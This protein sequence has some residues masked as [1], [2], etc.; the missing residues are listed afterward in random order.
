MYTS[1]IVTH[2]ASIWQRSIAASRRYTRPRATCGCVPL[3]ALHASATPATASSS[4]LQHSLHQIKCQAKFYRDQSKAPSSVLH[5]LSSLTEQVDDMSP[6][7]WHRIAQVCLQISSMFPADELVQQKVASLAHALARSAMPQLQSW[8]THT[9]PLDIRTVSDFHSW[10]EAIQACGILT[11]LFAQRGVPLAAWHQAV[12]ALARAVP[13]RSWKRV[14]AV[15]SL[16]KAW[17]TEATATAPWPQIVAAVPAWDARSPGAARRAVQM[18]GALA[19]PAADSNTRWPPRTPPPLLAAAVSACLATLATCG[20]GSTSALSTLHACRSASKLI[21]RGAVP[22]QDRSGITRQIEA[23]V[24]A[25]VEPGVAESAGQTRALTVGIAG[26]LLE[27]PGKP[28]AQVAA[29]LVQGSSASL[30]PEA[31]QYG[32]AAWK[33]ALSLV[34]GGPRVLGAQHAQRAT[35]Y[36]DALHA[37]VSA[38]PSVPAAQRVGIACDASAAAARA[39]VLSAQAAQGCLRAI[40]AAPTGWQDVSALRLASWLR[41]VSSLPARRMHELVSSPAWAAQ[42]L[43]LQHAADAMDLTALPAFAVVAVPESYVRLGWPAHAAAVRAAQVLAARFESRAWPTPIAAGIL[44]AAA[45]AGVILRD[46]LAPAQTTA[47]LH[48]LEHRGCTL[49]LLLAASTAWALACAGGAHATAAGVLAASATIASAVHS[50]GAELPRGLGQLVLAHA[51]CEQAGHELPPLPDNIL[52]AGLAHV[53]SARGGA[54]L[55]ST[56]LALPAA[57]ERA[58]PDAA[59]DARTVGCWPVDAWLGSQPVLLYAQSP[60][61]PEG[62]LDL[63][64]AQYRRVIATAGGIPEAQILCVPVAPSA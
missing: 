23:L 14:P 43:Q 36:A 34:L 63:H 25:Y 46:E 19:G 35:A 26:D 39:G 45:R 58:C 47:L 18:L 2:M 3:Q 56:G 62:T 8:T 10:N 9:G 6:S 12:L 17:A 41:S 4:S 49:S 13:G 28:L 38:L 1:H 22:L 37:V 24:Q 50:S 51:A 59:V 61:M 53:A 16:C 33:S 54:L 60:S 64:T 15:A 5:S 7:D 48:A 40:A 57:L 20:P 29:G 31:Q 27:L 30:A 44:R 11:E 55:R 21:H 42:V 32:T 52:N